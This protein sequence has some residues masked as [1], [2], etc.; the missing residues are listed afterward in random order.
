MNTKEIRIVTWNANGIIGKKAE[1]EVFLHSQ[2]IDVCLVSE[3]HLTNQSFVKIHGYKCYHSIH[4]DNQAKGGSAIFI[5]ESINHHEELPIQQVKCCGNFTASD[6]Q[7]PAEGV[8][9]PSSCC[10]QTGSTTEEK[11]HEMYTQ[12]CY[13]KVIEFLKEIIEV[14]AI[15]KT[16][17]PLVGVILSCC[18]ASVINKTKYE[19]MAKGFNPLE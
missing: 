7:Y 14:A 4:P 3:T 8:R 17:F 10:I 9:I 16:F 2:H 18:L 19:P 1:L 15:G 12:G 11:C 6:W 5:K 13:L